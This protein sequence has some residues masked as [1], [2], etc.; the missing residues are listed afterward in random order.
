MAEEPKK[1]RGWKP[2]QE[3]LTSHERQE[4]PRSDF[5]L[6]G[7]GQGPKGAGS[8]SYPIEDEGHARAALSRVSANGTPEEK[9][10]VRSAVHRKFPSIKELVASI[11]YHPRSRKVRKSDD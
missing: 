2:K 10:E 8:G 6:P 5:A 9:K 11:Y 1:K 4:M 7:K 3:H